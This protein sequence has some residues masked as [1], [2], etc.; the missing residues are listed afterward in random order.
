MNTQ[1]KVKVDAKS[2]EDAETMWQHFIAVS[3][4]STYAVCFILVLLWL[5]FIGF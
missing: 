1:N 3:K 2:L 5:V 4:V